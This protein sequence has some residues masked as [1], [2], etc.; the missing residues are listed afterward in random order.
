MFNFVFPVIGW[1]CARERNFLLVCLTFVYI[2]KPSKTNKQKVKNRKWHKGTET[3]K[4][5][6]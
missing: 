3:I 4:Y 6:R 5:K 1:E 2:K